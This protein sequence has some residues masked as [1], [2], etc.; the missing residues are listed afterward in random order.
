MDTFSG[1]KNKIDYS[2]SEDEEDV[3]RF[4]SVA[5][6][7]RTVLANAVVPPRAK[8]S[9]PSRQKSPKSV[10]T[11]DKKLEVAFEK[12]MDTLWA[13]TYSWV[14]E[15]RPKACGQY[16]THE[17]MNALE[18]SQSV[19]SH[20]HSNDAVG[21]KLFRGGPRLTRCDTKVG[22]PQG[23]GSRHVVRKVQRRRLNQPRKDFP[24]DLKCSG[25]VVTAEE[26]QQ[27]YRKSLEMS[28]HC[29]GMQNVGK[30]KMRRLLRNARL[31]GHSLNCDDQ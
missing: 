7:G 19:K 31:Y 14:E 1:M 20:S 11:V 26:V 10:D 18:G 27:C 9:Q 6:D 21:M 28:F 5:V 8:G 12:R 4:A 16:R 15:E 13:S 24:S 17:L 3:N 29:I 30:A 25:V 2:S 22:K 23:R